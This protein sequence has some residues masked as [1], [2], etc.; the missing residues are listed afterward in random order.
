MYVKTVILVTNR[1]HEQCREWAVVHNTMCNV[2]S[3]G[4]LSCLM[5]VGL[6]PTHLQGQSA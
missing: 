4:F 6:Q 3:I 1:A 2:Q 5:P